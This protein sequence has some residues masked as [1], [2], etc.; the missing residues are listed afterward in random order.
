MNSN[1]STVSDRYKER[2]CLLHEARKSESVV[3][4]VV[5]VLQLLVSGSLLPTPPAKHATTKSCRRRCRE[6]CEAEKGREDAV[7]GSKQ[8]NNQAKECSNGIR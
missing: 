7:S 1:S 4:V 6:R 8:T 5:V 2:V 3:V